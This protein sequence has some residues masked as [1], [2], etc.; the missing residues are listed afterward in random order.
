M[1]RWTNTTKH[2]EREA[3]SE[4]PGDRAAHKTSADRKGPTNGQRADRDGPESK[5]RARRDG[6]IGGGC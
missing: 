5:T 2:T 3:D 1:E 4:G 6:D